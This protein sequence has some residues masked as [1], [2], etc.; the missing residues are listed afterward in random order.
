[1]LCIKYESTKYFLPLLNDKSFKI[2]NNTVARKRLVLDIL[3]FYSF[4]VCTNI[5]LSLLCS[6]TNPHTGT[7]EMSIQMVWS[8][9]KSLDCTNVLPNK[10]QPQTRKK[11]KQYVESE[12]KTQKQ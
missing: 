2:Y 10:V 3:V 5:L 1:M 4:T 11:L 8:E 9:T 7:D 12:I 6:V